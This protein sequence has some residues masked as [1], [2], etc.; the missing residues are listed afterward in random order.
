MLSIKNL[1]FEILRQ[2]IVMDFSLNLNYGEVITLFG[3][4]GCGKTTILRLISSLETP[5]NGSIV[6]KF[7][8]TAYLFQE[9]RLLNN[10]TALKNVLICM[11]K[12][13]KKTV[14]EHF[15]LIG[16]SHK[17]AQKYPYEL[18]GGMAKRVAFMRA[19]LSSAD[20]LLLDEPFV[21][22]DMD[23]RKI[24]ANLLA[25]KLEAKEVACVLV[26]H[27][28]NE[29]IMLSNTVLFLAPKLM[30]IQKEISLNLALK[31]RDDAFITK[32][33]NDDFKGVI[34]YD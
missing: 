8:K 14:L 1:E 5:K 15:A 17:D 13:D 11:E 9:N 31:D 18:S 24:L 25:R 23:L 4:S 12:P 2:K 27:E 22:L 32:C 26:T 19:F 3:A 10:L 30:K 6:N 28:R 34:Y 20:L 29:A 21:G 7:R 33:L 16:L